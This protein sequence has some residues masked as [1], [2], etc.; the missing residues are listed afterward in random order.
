MRANFRTLEDL[1]RELDG[2]EVDELLFL[3]EYNLNLEA[4][5]I[6]SNSLGS[7]MLNRRY[8]AIIK[9]RNKLGFNYAHSSFRKTSGY[10]FT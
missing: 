7:R 8:W 6:M 5:Q 10:P 4:L 3:S 1:L 2:L 9:E